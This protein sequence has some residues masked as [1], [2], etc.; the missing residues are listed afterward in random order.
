[1]LAQVVKKYVIQNRP[2]PWCKRLSKHVDQRH[3]RAECRQITTYFRQ[4]KRFRNM[5]YSR[6]HHLAPFDQSR[7]PFADH[8]RKPTNIADARVEF[9]S[10]RIPEAGR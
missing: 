3:L 10:K 1:M 2:Y 7:A 5:R 4:H 9:C 8:R 6:F